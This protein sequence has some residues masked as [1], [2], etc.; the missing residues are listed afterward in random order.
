MD[1]FDELIPP[2]DKDGSLDLTHRNWVQL[3]AVL[4]TY[5]RD[6]LTL[7]IAFNNI[8]SLPPELG[9]LPLLRDLDCSCNRL[10]I[11][12][13]ELQAYHRLTRQCVNSAQIGRCTRLRR[14]KANGNRL[15]EVP[16]SL[17]K[18]VLL[19]TIILSENKL[20]ALPAALGTL[21]GLTVLR[22]ANNDLRTV[23]HELAA[24]TTLQEVDCS[25]NAKLDM[26][27]LQL[28]GKSFIKSFAATTLAH[29]VP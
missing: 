8:E 9:D 11:F 17:S 10:S 6:L 19:D 7:N 18:C 23:P 4:W 26:I 22:L 13:A 28:R 27:P 21:Q 29:A 2:P 24:V 25:G 14:L 15:T 16:A 20:T 1:E 5:G 12:P 3:D